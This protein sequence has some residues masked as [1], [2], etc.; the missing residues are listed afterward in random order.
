VHSSAQAARFLSFTRTPSQTWLLAGTFLVA[1]LPRL[2]ILAAAGPQS[3]ETWEYD[4]LARSIATGHGYAIAHFGHLSYAFGDGNLYSFASAAAYVL[5]GPRP[6][7]LAVGQA[8]IASLATP[9]ILA[10]GTRSLGAPTATLGAALAALHPGLLAYTLKLHP[11]GIDVLLLALAVLWIGRVGTQ[12]RDGLIAGIALG[13]NLMSR[14]TFFVAGVVGMVLQ[15]GRRPATRRIVSVGLAML[16]SVIIALPW[17]G[18]NWLVLGKPV[19]ISS[20][21]EDVWKGNN[22]AA[23]GSSYLASGQD[24]FTLMPTAM[25]TRLS[26]A[27]E[28]ELNDVF[29]AEIV[30]FIQHHPGDFLSLLG[31]KFYYFW[32]FSPQSGLLYP[33]S[34]LTAYQ[35][36]DALALGFAVLGTVWIVRRGSPEARRLLGLLLAISLTIAA[37]HA[38][39]YVEGRHRWGVEP[40]LLLLT[41]QGIFVLA[42]YLR[43]LTLASHQ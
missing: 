9:V 19:F 8:V 24:V 3:I 6:W 34:W 13:L 32:W 42:R 4:G 36:Y 10:I 31:R 11:L 2:A 40:L 28:L 33:S 17:V 16:V 20:G 38:M 37:L 12:P 18:R 14:P 26:T 39:S 1:L 29:G 7:L 22:P 41:A 27:S 15:L 43:G 23:S 25:R 5:L 35:V 30:E 21:L